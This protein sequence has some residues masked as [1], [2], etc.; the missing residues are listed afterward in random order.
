MYILVKSSTLFRRIY[1][2]YRFAKWSTCGRYYRQ[3]TYLAQALKLFGIK[4]QR[5]MVSW[6]KSFSQGPLYVV[7]T[8][9]NLRDMKHQ[10]ESGLTLFH[11]TTCWASGFCTQD[12]NCDRFCHFCTNDVLVK[13][14]TARCVCCIGLPCFIS[15][16]VV[17][18]VCFVEGC[19]VIPLMCEMMNVRIRYCCTRKWCGPEKAYFTW[20]YADKDIKIYSRD[21]WSFIRIIL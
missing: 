6:L 19:F 5:H 7:V 8:W 9:C 12:F 16:T 14:F 20:E 11:G 4:L 18:K 21:S 15:I 2:E 17:H 13:L 1:L 10:I 3:T